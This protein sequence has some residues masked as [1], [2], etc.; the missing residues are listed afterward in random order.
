MS[1]LGAWTWALWPLSRG[2]VAMPPVLK[3]SAA[4]PPVATSP[5]L[6]AS[7]VFANAKLWNPP[8]SAARD[9]LAAPAE[10]AARRI[11]MVG[12]IR[13]DGTLHAALYD[14]DTDQLLVLRHGQSIGPFTITAVDDTGVELTGDGRILRL[15]LDAKEPRP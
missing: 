6:E 4:S 9:E 1:A 8:P 3:S 5:A 13:Q 10:S 15:A 12:I 7:R 11:Q 2:T 14:F